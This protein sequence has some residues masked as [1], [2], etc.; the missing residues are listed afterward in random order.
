MKKTEKM[1]TRYM[2]NPRYHE[3]YKKI[4]LDREVRKG[5]RTF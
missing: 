3:D 2:F 4:L 1:I 5:L